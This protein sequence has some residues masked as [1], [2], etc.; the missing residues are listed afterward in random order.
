M[1][2]VVGASL[3]RKQ[4]EAQTPARP[5]I[6]FII[7][8]Q[9]RKDA[10]GAYGNPLLRTPHL[11][12]LASEGIR[13]EHFFIA[14]FPCSP[15]RAS[16]LTGLYPHTH[17][18]VVNNLILDPSL[19]N[20]GALLQ[21]AGYHTA[22]M[23]KWHLAGPN[24]LVRDE[25]GRALKQERAPADERTPPLRLGF[26]TE[27]SAGLHYLNYLRQLG[28]E[29][30]LPGRKVRGG[31]H[32]V[33]QDGHSVIPEEHF[34]SAFLAREAVKFLEA[35]RDAE[36]P[37][38]LG[39][40]FPGPH[41]PM[42]PPEPWD[43]LYHPEQ[44]V[45]PANHRDLM[46]HKPRSHRQFHWYMLREGL[47]PANLKR[48]LV[49]EEE[50]WDLLD[51]GHFGEREFKELMAHYYGF[52]TYLDQWIGYVLDAVDRLGL[53]DRTIVIFTSDHGEFMGSHGCIFKAMAMYDE[54]MNVPFLL[55]YPPLT[56]HPSP[57]KHQ[58]SAL[59]SSVDVVPTLLELVGVPMPHAVQGRSFASLLRGET[60]QHRDAVFTSFPAFHRQVRMVRTAEWKYVLNWRPRE[61]DELYHLRRD[62]GELHNLALEPGHEEVLR[63]MQ[64][65]LFAWMEETNDPWREEARAAAALP[66]REVTSL[67]FDFDQ[68]WEG[69]VWVPFRGISGLTIR[70][71]QL[72]GEIECPGFLVCTLDRPVAA[73]DYPV[74]LLRMRTTAGQ[75]AQFYWTTTDLPTWD[76]AK[77][78]RFPIQG[79]GEFH[80]YR[81][82]LS[83]HPLWRDRQITA[84]RLNPIRRAPG[85]RQP[86]RGQF[87]IDRLSGSS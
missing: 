28:L 57:I 54:L 18:V 35:Q 61:V 44:M 9:Q 59:V 37:F 19:P 80:T 49:Y 78:L 39:L 58:T 79:D 48:Y 21:Q 66:Y 56:H 76:E 25:Q 50:M 77:S 22:W 3:A 23:G 12:R 47:N 20:L 62:P 13:F 38:F 73:A 84:I 43:K 68:A 75:Q 2:A 15:S 42:T 24:R 1:G 81:L 45:L 70:N 51:R 85:D 7:T 72:I 16:F 11:D 30:P 65:R 31:H 60:E 82:E 41:R 71:G 53:R 4:V 32:T 34:V 67:D 29:E 87:A 64:E 83:P 26:E 86:L 63:E 6:L 74:L 69:G 55:R 33:I 10:M 5:N 52:I 27:V 40:S 17:G 8:D 14:A 46:T 36:R